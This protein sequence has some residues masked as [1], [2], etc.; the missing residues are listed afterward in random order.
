MSQERS[1]GL[2][3]SAIENRIAHTLNYDKAIDLFA[4]QK[5]RGLKL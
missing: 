4:E 2:A 5:T 3:I 1:S